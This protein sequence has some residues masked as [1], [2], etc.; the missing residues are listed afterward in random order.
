MFFT[1][2]DSNYIAFCSN[3]MANGIAACHEHMV[4]YPDARIVHN[5]SDSD[6]IS[7]KRPE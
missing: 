7:G 1:D 2:S 5:L 4:R 6:Y 3:H